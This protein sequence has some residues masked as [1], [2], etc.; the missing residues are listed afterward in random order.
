MIFI[1]VTPR[2]SVLAGCDRLVSEPLVIENFISTYELLD[3]RKFSRGANRGGAS[4]GTEG[5]RVVEESGK[6]ANSDLLSDARSRPGPA[7]S[8]DFCE[9]KVEPKRGPA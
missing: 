7:E 5:R 1:L 9:S 8:G 6:E 4:R 2:V 3:S